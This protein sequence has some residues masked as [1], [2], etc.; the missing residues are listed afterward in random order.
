MQT[1]VTCG[2]DYCIYSLWAGHFIMVGDGK[3]DLY[4]HKDGVQIK[5]II[6]IFK[7]CHLNIYGRNS[8]W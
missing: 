6:Y 8:F 5:A 1:H 4:K 7:S 3:F 2:M